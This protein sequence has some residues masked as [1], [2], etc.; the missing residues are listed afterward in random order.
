MAAV[1]TKRRRIDGA[2]TAGS[3]PVSFAGGGG[4]DDQHPAPLATEA[5]RPLSNATGLLLTAD[6]YLPAWL[7][8]FRSGAG[9]AKSLGRL[10]VRTSRALT[11]L[12]ESAEGSGGQ[13]GDD[14]EIWGILCRQEL[15][16]AIY[17]SVPPAVRENLGPRRLLAQMAPGPS[18]RYISRVEPI[19]VLPEPTITEDDTTFLVNVWKG[20]RV[21]I[22]QAVTG[23]ELSELFYEKLV[24]DIQR[25]CEYHY[26][27]GD[28]ERHFESS[29]TVHPGDIMVKLDKP[30]LLDR[31]D[32]S[33]CKATV[34]LLYSIGGQ[35]SKC[36]P[37]LQYPGEGVIS[38]VTCECS[39][40]SYG[41]DA[42]FDID[43]NTCSGEWVRN[44]IAFSHH[45]ET[46]LDI[47][48]DGEAILDLVR[49]EV[50]NGIING[51]R[52]SLN[53]VYFRPF[54]EDENGDF[55][56]KE[57]GYLT[58][59]TIRFHAEQKDD[60]GRKRCDNWRCWPE[61]PE[62]IDTWWKS[63][64]VT[65]PH[66]LPHIKGVKMDMPKKPVAKK[67]ATTK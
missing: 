11:Q 6:R 60:D 18:M 26:Y 23:E 65:I 37:L 31:T 54:Q 41:E 36:I 28:E 9:D 20:D 32:L 34:H 13:G 42:E 64:G 1:A 61:E 10:A 7:S 14:G 5:A 19:R 21:I 3:L 17:N 29:G 2:T 25:G 15:G 4:K 63:S 47:D 22:S 50:E 66:L 67:S 57:E 39:Y 49:N 45:D 51:L 30:F 44:G 52:L 12:L 53:F 62:P 38:D 48:G 59:F 46:F 56:S 40:D 16:N 24:P 35:K 8:V 55:I 43:G 27:C 58:H 33:D